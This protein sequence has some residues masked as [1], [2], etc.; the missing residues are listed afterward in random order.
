MSCALIVVE[1]QCYIGSESQNIQNLFSRPRVAEN[2]LS[3]KGNGKKLHLGRT[4]NYKHLAG[5]FVLMLIAYGLF[6][7]NLNGNKFKREEPE[8]KIDWEGI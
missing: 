5:L 6:R 4:M 7:E 3:R 8:D 1:K 2:L